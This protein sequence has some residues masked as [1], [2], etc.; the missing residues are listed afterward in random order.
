[1]QLTKTIYQRNYDFTVDLIGKLK[2]RNANV[3]MSFGLLVGGSR[4]FLEDNQIDDWGYQLDVIKVYNFFEKYLLPQATVTLR[5]DI[6]IEMCAHVHLYLYEEMG[7]L[8]D[9]SQSEIDE[10]F[11]GLL[12]VHTSRFLFPMFGVDEEVA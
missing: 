8:K 10:F 1:M 7:I 9:K 5:A 4:L 11:E 2:R 3:R 6:I 12:S